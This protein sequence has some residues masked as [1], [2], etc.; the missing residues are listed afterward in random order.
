MT[1]NR[2]REVT[3]AFVSLANSLVDDFDVKSGQRHD[4]SDGGLCA[5][6]I[7]GTMHVT[8]TSRKIATTYDPQKDA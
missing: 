8:A 4:G 6:N 5:S 2:E 3:Q 7:T 1:G